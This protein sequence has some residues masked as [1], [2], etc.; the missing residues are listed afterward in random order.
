MDV[1]PMWV[2]VVSL[3][4]VFLFFALGGH[5]RVATWWRRIR[6]KNEEE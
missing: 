4:A 5:E 3:V 1:V 2:K 6:G